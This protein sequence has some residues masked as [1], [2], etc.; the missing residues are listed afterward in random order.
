MSLITVGAP[1]NI[2]IAGV[3]PHALKMVESDVFNIA[4]RIKEIDPNLYV[5]V[6]EGHARPFVVMEHALDGTERMVS[7][8]DRLDS[9]ILD[10]LRYML[11]VPFERRFAELTKKIDAE[12]ERQENAWMESEAHDRMTWEFQRA[13][14]DSNLSNPMWGRYY[15]SGGSGRRRA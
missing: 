11:N 10:D 2:K 1:E 7:R 13:L 3:N 4:Q 6:H 12:N 15:M 8:Y 5:V 9:S 14:V